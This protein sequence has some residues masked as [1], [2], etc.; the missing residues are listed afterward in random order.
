MIIAALIFSA[1][2]GAGQPA[3]SLPALKAA[4]AAARPGDRVTLAPGVYVGSLSL[5]RLRGE[6]DRPITLAGADPA[7]PPTIRGDG[8]CL[9][10]IAPAYV[11]IENLILEGARGNGVNV[12]DGGDLTRPAPGVTLRALHVRDIGPQGNC[13]GIKLSGLSGFL[14][15]GC[16]IERWGSEGSAI[17]MVGCRDGVVRECTLRHS[18]TGGSSGVQMKGGTR[19]VIVRSCRFEHAGRRALN[20]GG[21]TG[22]AYFR[23]GPRGFEAAAVIVEGC[24]IIGSEAAVAFVGVDGADFRFNTVY[25]PSRWVLRILQETRSPGFVPSRAGRFTDNLVVFAKP[26]IGTPNIGDAT[27]APSF[28]FA[29]NVWYCEG[30]AGAGRPPLPSQESEG[31]YSKDPGLRAPGQGDFTPAPDGPASKA[32]AHAL[33]ADRTEKP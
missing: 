15:E 26:Q 30:D 13:D 17:D 28:T 21:S 27:D 2:L 14:V 7:N 10:L 19:D 5:D 8:E 24:T 11:V 22:L 31:T 29:R 3:D 32:G 16:T 23:P 4:L 25:R 12:D 9:H 20:I 18:D 6:K 33:P 1:L